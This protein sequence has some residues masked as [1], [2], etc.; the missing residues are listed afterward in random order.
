MADAKK[1]T[2]ELKQTFDEAAEQVKSLPKAPADDVKLKLYG[3]FKQATVG[4]NTT[5]KPGML[6]FRGKYKWDAWTEVKDKDQ[7][8]AMEEYIALV[9]KLQADSE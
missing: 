1:I 3:L 6:D 8:D 7:V 4:N 2:P 5:P 9:K